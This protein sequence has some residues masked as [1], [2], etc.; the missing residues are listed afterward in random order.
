[1]LHDHQEVRISGRTVDV[2]HMF[3][4]SDAAQNL[5]ASLN[6]TRL[7]GTLALLR[8]VSN[9]ELA[10]FIGDLGSVVSDYIIDKEDDL[11]DGKTFP[12]EADLR[13]FYDGAKARISPADMAGD[14]D[15]VVFP[16]DSAKS[17]AENMETYYTEILSGKRKRFT[18]FAKTIGLGQLQADD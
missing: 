12:T 6:F 3:T 18:S 14:A 4:G 9:V 11:R 7:V 13:V 15:G 17:I 2:G 16:W 1:Y 5:E 10:T 8:K